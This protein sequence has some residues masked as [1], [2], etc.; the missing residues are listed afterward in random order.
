MVQTVKTQNAVTLGSAGGARA[1]PTRRPGRPDSKVN[2]DGREALLSTAHDLLIESHGLPVSMNYICARAD[3]NQ[4]MV[5]YH[6]GSKRELMVA[7]FERVSSTWIEP[8]EK[9]IELDI[10]PRK[11]FE[12]HIKQI[13]RNFRSHP[14]FNRL[15][16]ELQLT[17]DKGVQRRLSNSFVDS[18]L[19]FYEHVVGEGVAAGVSRP[20]KPIHLFLSIVGLCD[21]IFAAQPM[22]EA[23]LGIKMT[24]S[25]EAELVEH[26]TRLVL[27]G[28]GTCRAGGTDPSPPLPPRPPSK[29]R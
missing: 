18:L 2:F 17:G 13:I 15:L 21:Y 27:D 22:L 16:A 5:R 3:I 7:L 25:L 29:C 28:I 14:Y 10:E 23:G 4:A 12:I 20:V 11:K 19:K 1:K 6:F 26:T 8:L 9:L 24:D